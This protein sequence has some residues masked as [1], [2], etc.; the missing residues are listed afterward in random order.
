MRRLIAVV[1][2]LAAGLIV[3]VLVSGNS[4]NSDNVYCTTPTGQVVDPSDCANQSAS[5][6]VSYWIIFSSRQYHPGQTISPSETNRVSANDPAARQA[7]GIPEDGEPPAQVNVPKAG[8]PEPE[9]PAVNKP[10]VP[11]EPEAPE[12]AYHAPPPPPEE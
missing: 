7:A 8:V 6:V 5:P 3:Y 1:V 10:V 11:A 2:A 9:E 4:G 12:P